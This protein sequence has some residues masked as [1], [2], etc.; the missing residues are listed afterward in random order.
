MT[1]A[2]DEA[3]SRTVRFRYELEAPPAKVWRAL[4]EPALLARWLTLP[5]RVTGDPASP[6]RL[7]VLDC[8]PERLIRYGWQEAS[9]AEATSVVSFRIA[10]NAAGGTRFEIV[11]QR[12][13][14]PLPKAANSNLRAL[15]CA[16]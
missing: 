6:T 9:D 14:R 16:A 11:H 5:D 10:P 4:T 2:D 13:L 8:V 15:S 3:P 7:S 1:A 12:L